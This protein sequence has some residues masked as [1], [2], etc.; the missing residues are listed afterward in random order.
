MSL[1]LFL[2]GSLLLILSLSCSRFSD[3]KPHQDSFKITFGSCSHQDKS[4]ILWDEIVSEKP[5][6]WIWCGDNI[7][8]DSEDM[9]VLRGKYQKQKNNPLYQKLKVQTRIEGIWDD[10]DYG[11]NDGGKNYVMKSASQQELLD[12]LE[13]PKEDARCN[14][15][16][17]Y[18][19]F[20]ITK[21]EI[22][23]KFILLDTRYFR[24]DPLMNDSNYVPNYTG[25]ILGAQQWEWLI[26]ELKN[27]KAD[28]HIIVSSIQ[29]LSDKHT[30][31]KWGNFPNQRKKLLNLL[32]KPNIKLPIILSGDRHIGEIS[33]LN[34]QGKSIT[35]IT[36][37]SLTHASTLRIPEENLYRLDSLIFHENYGVLHIPLK[38]KMTIESYLKGDGHRVWASESIY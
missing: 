32:S 38:K 13:V 17:V 19:S 11:L 20:D 33:R 10:H 14:R 22:Q 23:I 12:F 36:S 26:N 7:Y 28:V 15:E 35:E 6:L 30:E 34:W 9:Q 5:D 1:N 3:D 2:C 31:E 24:D 18:Y 16:G 27:S 25:T 37:S 21:N 4:Q 29:V 8:G